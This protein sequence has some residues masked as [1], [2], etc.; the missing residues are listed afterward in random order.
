MKKEKP[1]I[2]AE[3]GS[4]FDQSLKKAKK[5]ILAAKNVAQAL[6]NSII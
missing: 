3:R 5:M 4:N 6:L 1:Y 2:I